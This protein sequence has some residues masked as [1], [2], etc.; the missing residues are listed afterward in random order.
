MP[1]KILILPGDLAIEANAVRG[2]IEVRQLYNSEGNPE[3]WTVSYSTDNRDYLATSEYSSHAVAVAVASILIKAW[4]ENTGSEILD[5][6]MLP[7]AAK[8]MGLA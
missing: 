7:L 5:Y 3:R 1:N 8:F 6:S 2:P 4:A